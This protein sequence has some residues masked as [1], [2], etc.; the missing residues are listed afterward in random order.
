MS[1]QVDF[2]VTNRCNAK[3]E[4][5][6]RDATPHQGL[7]SV[8]VFDAT[9]ERT[10][11]YRDTIHEWVA[12]GLWGAEATD[13]SIS[14]CGL[15]EPLLHP[16]I[17][18]FVEQVKAAG[19]ECTV[20]SNGS[21]LTKKKATQLIDAGLDLIQLNI[22]DE[23]ERYEEVYK[24]PYEPTRVHVERFIKM[25]D[26]TSTKASIVLVDY[27][28]DPAHT[29]KMKTYW[30]E[31]GIDDFTE[32]EI[33]NR[34]G[35]LF[36]EGM[37]YTSFEEVA[38]AQTMFTERNIAPMC[39]APFVYLFIG[40]DGLYYLCCSDWRKQAPVGSVFDESLSSIIGEKLN[41][42]RTRE[43]VCV[44]CN[45]DPA[46]RVADVMRDI[47]DGVA[48]QAE[49]DAMVSEMAMVGAM[50]GPAL[51]QIAARHSDPGK[52]RK[53]IPVTGN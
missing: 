23:G 52:V 3:C 8:E 47:A 18:Y 19:F 20:S 37:E 30:S 14:L 25:I 6:P 7:M 41:Y 48:T 21:V 33:M 44:N 5:C 32:F 40:Y 46:N 31:R 43:P 28:Q 4:F 50:F 45:H 15:G 51:D 16:K 10:I 12:E 29:A 27:L 36:V 34:G 13:I 22:A 2:E 1:I 17:I 9:L 42:L 49:L 11:E 35:A 39:I 26:G 38:H 24:L 53:L